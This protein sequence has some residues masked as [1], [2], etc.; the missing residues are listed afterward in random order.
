MQTTRST[1]A[2]VACLQPISQLKVNK[3]QISVG[4]GDVVGLADTS[5]LLIVGNDVVHM[6]CDT[7]SGVQ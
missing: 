5:S 2:E 4:S 6:V 1:T 3:K 7:L